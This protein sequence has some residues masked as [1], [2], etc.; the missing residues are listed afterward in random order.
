MG[1]GNGK[2]GGRIDGRI[3]ERIVGRIGGRIGGKIGGRIEERIDGRIDF[4]EFRI[5]SPYFRSEIMNLSS[6]FLT[7]LK[8]CLLISMRGK[9]LVSHHCQ[10][11]KEIDS[12]WVILKESKS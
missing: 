9:K 5:S 8:V 7:V 11:L 2:I 3:E 4:Y 10:G 6:S 1:K 12:I